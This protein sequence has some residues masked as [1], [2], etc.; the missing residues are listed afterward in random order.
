M[1]ICH[2][3]RFIFLKTS[4]T[5]GTSIEIALSKF[6]GASDV[7]TPISLADE[8]IRRDLGYPGPRNYRPPFAEYSSRDWA[9]A[10]ATLRRKELYNHIPA[11]E[12]RRMIDPAVW[13][14][15]FKFCFERN[16]WDRIISQYYWRC[17]TEPRPSLDEFM[18][19][20][21]LERLDRKGFGIYTIRGKVA[22]DRVCRFERLQEELEWLRA[23]LGLPEPLVLP[24]A[25]GS[26]RADRRPYR[27]VFD[28]GQ[29]RRVAEVFGRELALLG[30]EF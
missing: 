7:I 8:A 5:A 3:Y 17:P 26:L 21:V 6:C 12:A 25:K 11:R 29:R 2:P 14:T 27:E 22:V 28:E 9:F 24:S 10:A 23:H 13:N 30:Y 1:I 19:R 4:K 15:Y 18:T 16:P 20:K